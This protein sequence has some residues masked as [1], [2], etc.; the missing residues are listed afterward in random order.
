MNS[1][2][3]DKLSFA[4]RIAFRKSS[5]H[6]GACGVRGSWVKRAMD[7]AQMALGQMRVNLGGRDVAVAKHLLHR[8]Q[9]GAAFQ[10]MSREAMAKRMRTDPRQARLR[11]GPSL[12]C[13]EK[14]LSSH[15]APQPAG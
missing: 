14:S 7:L 15:R 9:I 5:G 11:D 13:L 4:F 2:R 3:L 8:T 6:L 10:Q 1:L 12:E